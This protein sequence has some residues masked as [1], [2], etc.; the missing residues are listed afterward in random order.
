[1]FALRVTITL[2]ACSLAYAQAPEP[3]FRNTTTL[4]SVPVRVIDKNGNDVNGL[5]A[6]DF[7]LIDNGKPQQ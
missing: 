5:T 2:C 4:Q 3:I 6:P 7:T 1:M